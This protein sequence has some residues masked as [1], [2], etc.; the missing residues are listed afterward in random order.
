MKNIKFYFFVEKG[1]KL[2]F[3]NFSTCGE[4]GVIMVIIFYSKFLTKNIAGP[5]HNPN[6]ITQSSILDS[7]WPKWPKR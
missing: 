7:F 1:E 2:E 4:R 5:L 6:G 3:Q